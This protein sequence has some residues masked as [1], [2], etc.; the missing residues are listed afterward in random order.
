MQGRIGERAATN[1]SSGRCVSGEG[2]SG[3][4]SL[5]MEEMR[6]RTRGTG[7]WTPIANGH[8]CTV[9]VKRIKK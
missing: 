7:L 1:P 8:F 9:A 2:V 6:V 3:E 4:R 5:A